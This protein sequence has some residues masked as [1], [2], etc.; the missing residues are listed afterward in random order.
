M[1][2]LISFY[3]FFPFI[4]TKNPYFESMSTSLKPGSRVLVTGATGYIGTHVVD[5]FLQ[6]GYVVIGTSRSAAKAENI[7]KY[8]DEKYGP[9]KFEIYEAGDLQEEGVFD[10]A[11][12]GLLYV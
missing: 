6:A 11:V 8:F 9:G 10:G 5:Q 3:L 1:T 2:Y 7:R 4:V 12:K